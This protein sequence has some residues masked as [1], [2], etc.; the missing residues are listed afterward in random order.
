MRIR[1]IA[2]ACALAA[3]LTAC[4]DDGGAADGNEPIDDPV[5]RYGLGPV[6]DPNTT[7]QDD[8]VLIDDGPR[9]IRSVSD[10]G[11]VWTMDGNAKGVRDVRP[12]KIMFATSNAVGR[13]VKVEPA[14]EDVAVT[15][16]P[17]D[18]TSV[19]KDGELDIDRPLDLNDLV[20][21]EIPGLTKIV[22][23]GDPPPSSEP[24]EPADTEAPEEPE[25]TEEPADTTESEAPEEPEVTEPAGFRVVD[26]PQLGLSARPKIKPMPPPTT[27]STY[28]VSAGDLG[29]EITRDKESISLKMAYG[30]GKGGGVKFKGSVTVKMSFDNPSVNSK[31]S[32]RGG[33]MDSS[34]VSIRGL[35]AIDI[36]VGVGTSGTSVDNEKRRLEIPVKLLDAPFATPIGPMVAKWEFKFI[37]T[38]GFTQKKTTVQSSASYPLRGHLGFQNGQLQKPTLSPSRS[39]VENLFGPTIG[40]TGLLAAVETKVSIGYGIPLA[41]AGPYA[42]LQFAAGFTIGSSAG[43]GGQCKET[44]VNLTGGVGVGLD[45]SEKL[46]SGLVKFLGES[47]KQELDKAIKA[48][49]NYKEV[50]I[51][52]W[53]DSEPNIKMC[54]T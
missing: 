21:Q 44:T 39:L 2:A 13:V 29:A 25:N 19:I 28:K 15:L 36:N 5:R 38:T 4:S 30:A 17:A 47:I 6:H 24:E 20:F 8:V 16:G 37:I 35:K 3:S 1:I 43:I 33:E 49:A 52:K 9:A 11:L 50:E 40:V 7:Y 32:M 26:P 27:G 48:K 10:D 22:D 12:G 53:S 42:K 54:K 31:M 14:G 34:S 51:A 18:I 23:A 45:L 46:M 41:S